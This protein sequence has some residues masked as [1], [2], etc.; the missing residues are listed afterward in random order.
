[1]RHNEDCL[2][3]VEY[4]AKKRVD[5]SVVNLAGRSALEYSVNL[6]TNEV[7]NFLLKVISLQKITNIDLDTGLIIAAI[8]CLLNFFI[9][10]FCLRNGKNYFFC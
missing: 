7:L 8:H 9:Q 3:L 1:M 10:Y 2:K 4:L 5:L 6:E